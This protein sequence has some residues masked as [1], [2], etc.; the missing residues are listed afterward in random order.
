MFYFKSPLPPPFTKGAK[1]KRQWPDYNPAYSL[2]H[3][4]N[5]R[6]YIAF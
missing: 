2:C 5:L 4:L 1:I 3:S 6:R